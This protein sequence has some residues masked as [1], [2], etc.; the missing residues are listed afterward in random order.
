MFIRLSL[1]SYRLICHLFDG[2]DIQNLAGTLR[3]SSFTSHL[4]LVTYRYRRLKA[5]KP[6]KEKKANKR[7]K[8]STEYSLGD[9][10]PSLLIAA[11]TTTL[12]L[13]LPLPNAT[14]DFRWRQ[15]WRQRLSVY[16]ESLNISV[17]D[18]S[19][20]KIVTENA[21]RDWN[22]NIFITEKRS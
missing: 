5:T 16:P 12:V 4:T 14:W 18:I 2:P 17:V 3:Q 9:L 10:S 11:A 6:S 7:K 19:V 21:T 1:L 22:R 13:S 8:H 15:L 20:H